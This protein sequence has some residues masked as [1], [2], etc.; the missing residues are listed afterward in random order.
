MKEM[1]ETPIDPAVVVAAIKQRAMQMG[2]NDFE[3][4]AFDDILKR[5]KNGECTGEQ[6][7]G[8]AESIIDGKQD[9]H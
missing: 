1:S 9:Y 4:Y 2:A 6:A 8:E 3:P 7:I 5:L